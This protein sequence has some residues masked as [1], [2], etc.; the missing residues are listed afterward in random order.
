MLLVECDDVD[1]FL[2]TVDSPTTSSSDWNYN[3]TSFK[4]QF[5]AGIL[6]Y[7]DTA[8]AGGAT[9]WDTAIGGSAGP[10]GVR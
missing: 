3:G 7:S 6:N 8:T 2:D 1:V 4:P 5:A 9:N 10:G